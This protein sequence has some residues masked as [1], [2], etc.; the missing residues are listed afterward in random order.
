[1]R[2]HR[3]SPSFTLLGSS[4]IA[5]ACSLSFAPLANAAAFSEVI[6]TV[7]PGGSIPDGPV[8]NGDW[9]S[10]PFW[11]ELVSPVTVPAE[12]N[13][14]NTVVIQGLVHN[15]RGDLHVYLENP[16]GQRFNVIV[17]PGYDNTSEGAGDSGG[18]LAG[19]YTFVESGGASV[20]QG[21]SF[22]SGGT[23]D[24]YLNSGG[25]LWTSASYPIANDVF[26]EISGSAGTWKL[27]LRDW[28]DG[29]P[30]AIT[31][32]WL[33]GETGALIPFCFGDGTGEPCPCT[34]QIGGPGR[35]CKNSKPGSTGGLLTA[36]HST[37]GTP[38]PS[39]TIASS[40]LGL[41]A[42]GM[43]PGSYAIFLQ[44]TETVNGG[45]GSW[46]PDYDGL[47]CVA[48]TLVRLGRVTTLGGANTLGGI[49][50]LAGLSGA[51]TKHYQAVYRN[52]VNFCTP[53]TLNTSNGLTVIWSP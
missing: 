1:M 11:P 52:A 47:V 23:Y 25:G 36:V 53:A 17:R 48:G 12:L 24:Q 13:R 26:G 19:T 29:A 2:R 38:S 30:G 7:G 50:S 9:N 21:K 28:F 10:T 14:V 5:I 15:W 32:W 22:I 34:A 46:S 43:L 39:V 33:T 27:H 35:G 49:A 42:E 3:A 41:K 44:G 16:A 40:E 18:F 51:Q 4:A 6:S 45:F 37:F 31:G 20:Q 8:I